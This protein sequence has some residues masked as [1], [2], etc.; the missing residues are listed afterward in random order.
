M[1]LR[2]FKNTGDARRKGV[3]KVNIWLFV[4][5]VTWETLGNHSTKRKEKRWENQMG[6]ARASGEE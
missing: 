3:C 1:F 4:I 2:G 6:V 5:L